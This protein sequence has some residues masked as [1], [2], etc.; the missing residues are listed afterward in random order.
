MRKDSADR[1][2]LSR[3]RFDFRSTKAEMYKGRDDPGFLASEAKQHKERRIGCLYEK[4]TVTRHSRCNE[5]GADRVNRS[6]AFGPSISGSIIVNCQRFGPR[7][8]IAAP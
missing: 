4:H 6:N 2:D 8:C 3:N 1:I 7:L 5:P